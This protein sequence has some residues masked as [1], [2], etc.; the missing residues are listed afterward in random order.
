L[1]PGVAG[2]P[3]CIVAD[4]FA[5][6]TVSALAAMLVGHDADPARL[7]Q[8]AELYLEVIHV[9]AGQVA[10]AIAGNEVVQ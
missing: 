5:T 6:R 2:R 8:F 3:R 9:D 7:N 10:A 1:D 4:I